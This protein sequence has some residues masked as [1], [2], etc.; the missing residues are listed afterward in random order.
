MVQDR[1]LKRREHRMLN[2]RCLWTNGDLTQATKAEAVVN[3]RR[4]KLMLHTHAPSM[5]LLPPLEI[6]IRLGSC[7]E[8]TLYWLR[9]RTERAAT[10]TVRT[11]TY[12][13]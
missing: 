2:G 4:S 9:D 10:G 3:S 1:A 8:D 6:T 11:G 5:C 13:W 12:L 7:V